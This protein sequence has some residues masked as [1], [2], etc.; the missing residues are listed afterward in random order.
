MRWIAAIVASL[1]EYVAAGFAATRAAAT[2]RSHRQFAQVMN[3]ALLFKK[4]AQVAFFPDLSGLQERLT[5]RGRRGGT[6][7]F[8]G[9]TEATRNGRRFD[10]VHLRQMGVYLFAGASRRDPRVE[11]GSYY[12][13]GN[14][15][16][17]CGR[18]ATPRLPVRRHAVT[19]TSW[20]R[21]RPCRR[22]IRMIR[23]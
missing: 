17:G 10:Q 11:Q 13:S 9:P 14:T 12:L 3:M 22:S 6:G 7:G 2:P 21:R 19:G 18:F 4:A 23:K 16:A 20:N 8:D 5:W 1:V 15:P